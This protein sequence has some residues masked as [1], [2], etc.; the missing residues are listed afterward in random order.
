MDAQT[1]RGFIA[2]CFGIA[3]FVVGMA[4]HYVP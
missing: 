1:R 4:V 2:M 3:L